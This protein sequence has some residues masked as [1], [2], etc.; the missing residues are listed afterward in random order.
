MFM[1]VFVQSAKQQTELEELR[2]RV[3]QM[4]KTM[5]WWSDC[6]LNWREKWSQVRAERNAAREEL[7]RMKAGKSPVDLRSQATQTDISVQHQQQHSAHEDWYF[8]EHMATA[9]LQEAYR[10]IAIER[11]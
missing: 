5:K 7:K 9:K 4:E 1:F 3:N 2:S 10:T 8:G 6:T 11:E